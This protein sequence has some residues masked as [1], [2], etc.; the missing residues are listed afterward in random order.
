MLSFLTLYRDNDAADDDDA[1][2]D[3]ERKRSVRPIQRR[4]WKSAI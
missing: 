3:D 1:A 2:A 4:K